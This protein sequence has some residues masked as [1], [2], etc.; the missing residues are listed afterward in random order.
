M[1]EQL[2]PLSVS[3][4][5]SPSPSRQHTTHLALPHTNTG[6]ALSPSLLLFPPLLCPGCVVNGSQHHK[7]M[8]FGGIRPTTSHIFDIGLFQA[9]SASK[10]D[11][12]FHVDR[13][14]AFL[15]WLFPPLRREA[16]WL[17]CLLCQLSSFHFYLSSTCVRFI[18]S[19]SNRVFC[20]LPLLYSLGLRVSQASFRV[21]CATRSVASR[22]AFVLSR[23]VDEASVLL[24][25]GDCAEAG[26]C[27]CQGAL[28][29]WPR[30]CEAVH[31]PCCMSAHSAPRSLHSSRL[32]TQQPCP[33]CT[34][35]PSGPRRRSH[36]RSRCRS[37]RPW[38]LR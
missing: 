29:Q 5:V 28:S 24:I 1:A 11:G 25:L 13:A 34:L 2:G 32:F 18:S 35:P 4:Y 14:A 9:R 10:R 26:P 22:A 12:P 30:S 7:L 21:G 3:L 19:G 27:H 31:P 15:V 37:R 6:L 33:P 20:F 23:W 16:K 36:N 8:E 38:T 17:L